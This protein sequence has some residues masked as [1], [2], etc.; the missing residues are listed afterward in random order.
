[1]RRAGFPA[2]HLQADIDIDAREWQDTFD[3]VRNAFGRGSVSVL[4]GPRGTGKTQMAVVVAENV[5][6]MLAY[7]RGTIEQARTRY[8]TAVELFVTI[9]ETYGDN[10]QRSERAAID[11]FV[12]PD[13]LV[14]DEV[15]ERAGT[16]WEQRL[17]AAI[18]D[19]R[20]AGMKDTILVGNLKP[21]DVRAELG[22]SIASR[23]QETG[24][25][26]VA[27]WPSF[28]TRKAGGAA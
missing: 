22:T 18:V 6:R 4:I 27:D 14:I 21:D 11:L 23:A 19:R 2:R 20:Y 7:H 10:A 1:M 16:E 15:Q 5:E 25:I 28:R 24:G 26:Y 13:L 12:K 8:T 9:K 17:L 3:A